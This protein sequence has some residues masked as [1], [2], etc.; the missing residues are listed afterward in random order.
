MT[1]SWFCAKSAIVLAEVSRS[2]VTTLMP[3]S[4]KYPFS[5]AVSVATEEIER[6]MPTWTV[7]SCAI[8]AEV[9]A[10]KAPIAANMRCSMAIP[11]P[12]ASF[13][14]DEIA[15]FGVTLEAGAAQIVERAHDLAP[16]AAAHGAH[17]ILKEFRPVRQGGPDRGKT[18]ARKARRLG[19]P[20]LEPR[21][22]PERPGKIEACLAAHPDTALEGRVERQ[23]AHAAEQ[24]Q[25]AVRL[26]TSRQRP[27]HL[28][29]GKNV[30][31]GV[32]HEY[33]LDVG[34]RP[35][36]GGDGIAGFAGNALAQRHP[37]VKHAAPRGRRIDR[38]RLA[39]RR[40]E[41]AP[42]HDLGAQPRELRRVGCAERAPADRRRLEQRVAPP[43]DR[44]QMEDGVALE[45]AVITEEL[46]VR[47][48]RLDVTAGV[49][50]AFEHH[51]GIRR[52]PD[53]IGDAFHH[54]ERRS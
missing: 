54:R 12:P 23:R 35:V 53:V 17:Q 48:F 5:I 44:R 10:T 34:E 47:P 49:E 50:I 15:P 19:H 6:T 38:N 16:I 21:I 30:D 2:S 39:H 26:E 43:R 27:I 9:L 40:L 29:V 20:G 1:C 41:C 37:D 4:L 25:V 13:C 7:A 18:L 33:V 42:D 31:I 45:R 32:D 46:T 51:L 24:N 52:Y 8:P 11:F 3:A 14:F 36:T 28:R 22:R